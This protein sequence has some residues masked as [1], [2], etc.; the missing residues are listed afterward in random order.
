MEMKDKLIN[1]LKTGESV[2]VE[3]KSCTNK[4][5]S[6]VYD[7]ICSFSNR[8]GGLIILGVDDDMNI[9]GI[10]KNQILDLKKNII[11][12]LCNKELFL[13]TLRIEPEIVEV[14]EK[15]FIVIEGMEMQTKI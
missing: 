2:N 11:N 3:F 5:S 4:I 1:A 14:D 7:T 15:Y 13:P 6:S 9:V 10:N 8:S 12:S